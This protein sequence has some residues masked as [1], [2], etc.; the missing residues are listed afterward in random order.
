V[1]DAVLRA[2]A[3]RAGGQLEAI[4]VSDCEAVT[5]AAFLALVTAS[6]A[7][8]HELRWQDDF[9]AEDTPDIWNVEA[10]LRAA[11]ELR[12]F[13]VDIGCESIADA[14]RLLRNEPPF[15]PLRVRALTVQG[16]G[17]APDEAAV[18]A[19]AA[20][21]AGH[22]WLAELTLIAFPL[23]T[24]A[25]LDALVDAALAR[26]LR[27]LD[28]RNCLLPPASAPAL[29][30]LLGGGLSRLAL[31]DML[32]APAALLLG[33]ALRASTTLTCLQLHRA[34]VWLDPAAA[35]LVLGALVSHPSLRELDVSHNAA[36]TP[37]QQGIAGAL[38]ATLV[39]ANAPALRTLNV[40]CC[41]LG[42]A[43]LGLLAD[44]LAHNTHLRTLKCAD[45]GITEAL[46]RERLLPA[47]QANAALRKL[48]LVDEE[49]VVYTMYPRRGLILYE[50]QDMV[51]A[52]AAAAPQ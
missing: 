39:A 22:A 24:A 45:N 46:A 30:R 42:D 26:R 40:E 7:T 19:L 37:A 28:L 44:A 50:L 12:L 9:I 49:R 20:D 47:V 17:E 11:P 33:N 21:V 25:S 6:G 18:L 51:A 13:E 43:G 38:I 34:N 41:S 4:D 36:G 1:T 23:N 3:A 32:D 10:L 52:R 29:A 31:A 5:F 14:A 27:A 16:G 2:A 48:V 15:A 35:V 8:L